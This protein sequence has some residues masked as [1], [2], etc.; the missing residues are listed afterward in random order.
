M[1]INLIKIGLSILIWPQK[2]MCVKLSRWKLPGDAN[3]KDPKEVLKYK[4]SFFAS[5]KCFKVENNKIRT[6]KNFQ[7]LYRS[8]TK[9]KLRGA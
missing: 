9:I 5:I 1:T 7:T 8:K 6:E 4:I 3:K 2:W